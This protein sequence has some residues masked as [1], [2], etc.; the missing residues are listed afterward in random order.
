MFRRTILAEHYGPRFLVTRKGYPLFVAGKCEPEESRHD[1]NSSRDHQPVRDSDRLKELHLF[2]IGV[3]P[4]I[5]FALKVAMGAAVSAATMTLAGEWN[6]T[7][8][9]KPTARP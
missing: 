9:M 1:K 2:S 6:A 8:K 7:A 3:G 4:T 5:Y